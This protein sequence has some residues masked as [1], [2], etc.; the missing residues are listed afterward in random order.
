MKIVIEGKTTS[1]LHRNSPKECNNNSHWTA[2]V[3]SLSRVLGQ[4]LSRAGFF[5]CHSMITTCRLV[6]GQFSL[7]SWATGRTATS[8]VTRWQ[9][10]GPARPWSTSTWSGW[11]SFLFRYKG[12]TPP[13]PGHCGTKH[14]IRMEVRAWLRISR[15]MLVR[16]LWKKIHSKAYVVTDL[17]S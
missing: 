7:Y 14:W 16:C 13:P 5:G 3:T 2:G 4:T 11:T 17:C 12:K 15:T 10:V 8:P 1:R 6:L 9:G